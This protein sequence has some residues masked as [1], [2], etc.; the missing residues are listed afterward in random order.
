MNSSQSEEV[1]NR[2]ER[3]VLLATSFQKRELTPVAQHHFVQ[4]IIFLCFP[5]ENSVVYI[6]ILALS[7]TDVFKN[8]SIV[9]TIPKD[10]ERC[11]WCTI[12]EVEFESTNGLVKT[13]ANQ[14]CFHLLGLGPT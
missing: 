14:V 4:M 13:T 11:L 10:Y 7:V 2:R 5:V 12:V 1:K 9:Q 6:S 8:R 3:G